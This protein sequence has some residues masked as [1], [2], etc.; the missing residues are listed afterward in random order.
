MKHR[1][2]KIDPVVLGFLTTLRRIPDD[3]VLSVASRDFEMGSGYSCLLGN[4]LREVLVACAAAPAFDKAGWC[5]PTVAHAELHDRFGGE[6]SEW[7]NIY[8]GVLPRSAWKE[9]GIPEAG[10]LRQIE[11]AFTIRVMEAAGVA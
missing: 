3:I 6:Y 2:P 4:T 10:R 11:E 1:K 5:W 8:Y 7:K 9:S